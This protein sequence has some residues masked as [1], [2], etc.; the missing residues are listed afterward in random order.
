[1]LSLTFLHQ[2]CSKLCFGQQDF[3][4]I[5]RPPLSAVSING[6]DTHSTTTRTMTEMIRVKTMMTMVIMLPMMKTTTVM[7]KTKTMMVT[8][9]IMNL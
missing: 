6:I 9:M 8:I 3:I 2:I 4:K 1:M 5:I 7:L